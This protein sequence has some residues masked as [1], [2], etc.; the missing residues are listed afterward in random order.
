MSGI[1]ED[2][3]IVSLTVTGKRY[4]IKPV[5]GEYGYC[6][7]LLPF[8]LAN[9]DES[10]QLIEQ[11]EGLYDNIKIYPW[12][13]HFQVE[14]KK[15]K[16]PFKKTAYA[17]LKRGENSIEVG[18]HRY[19]E[20]EKT[21]VDNILRNTILGDKLKQYWTK[22]EGVSEKE[23]QRRLEEITHNVGMF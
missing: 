21:L 3:P 20:N 12:Y 16:F 14:A 15:G 22:E 7:L 9:E 5:S 19:G 2:F 23:A 18:A 11:I 4:G 17:I 1:I 10:R 6:G 8:G 13:D